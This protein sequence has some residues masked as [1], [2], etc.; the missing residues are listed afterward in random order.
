MP[1]V[2]RSDQS[3]L[4]R[5][6]RLASGAIRVPAALT[7][8][9]VL[10]YPDVSYPSGVRRELRSPKEVFSQRHLD[11]YRGVAVTDLHPTAGVDPSS[12]STLARGHVCDDVRVDGDKVVANLVIS[13][14]DLIEKIERGERREVSGGYFCEL[15]NTPG[16]WE[17]EPYDAVQTNLQPNHVAIGGRGWGRCGPEVRLLL[18]GAQEKKTMNS[19]RVIRFDRTDHT[20]TV[21]GTKFDALKEVDQVREAARKPVVLRL[22]A[23]TEEDIR[24]LLQN[25]AGALAAVQEQLVEYMAM[26]A[27]SDA[28]V[29]EMTENMPA[30]ED[31]AVEMAA[32]MADAQRRADSL[33]PGI[34]IPR[35]TKPIDIMRLALKEVGYEVADCSNEY[36]K[37][38]FRARTDH[39]SI[40]SV[41]SVSAD[42]IKSMAEPTRKN[43]NPT[44]NALIDAWRK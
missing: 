13:D 27:E 3:P 32:D 21:D 7:R 30:L 40:G 26:V 28:T 24:N 1:A 43:K 18:D 44:S 22:D 36:V 6:E 35:G 29:A 17:G 37:G 12:W 9:G 23:L 42:E 34:E 25:L 15:K 41:P 38:A 2:F 20:I 11:A 14:A 16:V 10:E 4:G 33:V 8:I 5:V 39:I 31:A 19:A